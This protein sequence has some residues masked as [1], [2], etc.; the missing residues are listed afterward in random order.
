MDCLVSAMKGIWGGRKSDL[1]LQLIFV[2]YSTEGKA[3]IISGL[4]SKS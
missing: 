2:C 3:D 4:Q 1:Q